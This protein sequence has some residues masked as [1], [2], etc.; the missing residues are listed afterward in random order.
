MKT[1]KKIVL[2]LVG[3]IAIVIIGVATTGWWLSAPVSEATRSVIE[4]SPQF[5]DGRFV[6]AEPQASME[7]T[8]ARIVEAFSSHER[9][10]PTGKIPVVPIDPGLLQLP[11]KPGLRIAWLGHAGVLIEI[12]GKRILVDPVLSD[13]ASPFTFAGPKRFHPPPVDIPK[14]AGIDGVV[15][16][17]NHYDHLDKATILPL[18]KQ[19]TRFFVPLGNEG[20][21]KYWKIP[22]DQINQ[23]DW[24]QEAQLG[25]IKIVATPS[26]HYSN[27]GTFDYKKTLWASWSIIGPK[28][29]V[30]VSGDTGY[31]KLF[32]DIGE[33]FGPFDFSVIK[34]GAYG[35]GQ[36][37][38]DVHMTPEKAVQVHLDVKGKH[39][40]PVH[41]ATFNLAYHPWDEPIIRTVVA[42]AEKKAALLT[43]K[44]GQMVDLETDVE[45]SKWWEGIE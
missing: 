12:D 22:A 15:I 1:W 16:T 42:A 2:A 24:W 10:N 26:R 38:N 19:A 8:P 20:Q 44:V 27:R 28:H 4:K 13:R 41:W 33:K 14:L 35:P 29:R 45:F 30:F 23:L 40:L 9:T 34:V 7:V 6:N 36:S 25:D 39:M 3:I 37:W 21:L 17:H 32:T 18:S 31:A 5:Q 43:P 11:P